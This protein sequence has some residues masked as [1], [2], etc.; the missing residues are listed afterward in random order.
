VGVRMGYGSN[1][2]QFASA[3]EYRNDE[4]Q[5]LDLT[6][7]VRN[8]WL[9]RNNFKYQMTQ[10]W[11]LLGKLNHSMSDSSQGEFYGGGYTEAEVG[12]AYRPSLFNRMSTLAKYTYFY[13]I[14]TTDQVT[15]QVTSVEFIQ[16]SHIAAFDV[17]FDVTPSW[18][19]GTK[20][21][22]RLGEA[23]IDRTLPQFFD[24]AAMLAAIRADWRFMKGW[25]SMMEVR[26]L[27][28]TSVGERRRGALATIYRYIGKNMKV[29]VGYNFTDFS[30]DLTDLGFNHKG[31]FFN[32]VGTK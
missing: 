4:A 16:K 13:N 17:S 7:T 9:F 10:D 12:Y 19:L 3:V 6:N 21:A 29:G 8:A 28:L 18:T 26:T 11:R 30:D 15:A 1:R 24:S 27:N 23:S 25:E 31:I 22:Y 32:F 20:Y 2:M 14:P 5:Q